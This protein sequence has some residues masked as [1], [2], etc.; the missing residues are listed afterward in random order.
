[1]QLAARPAIVARV[2]P[3]RRQ[4]RAALQSGLHRQPPRCCRS[5]QSLS[6]VAATSE[7]QGRSASS[8]GNIA[9]SLRNA[10]NPAPRAAAQLKARD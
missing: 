7:A 4:W 10:G 9:H 3:G 1:V 8:L 2:G 6:H 5:R